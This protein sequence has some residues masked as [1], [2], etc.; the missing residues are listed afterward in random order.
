MDRLT[1]IRAEL[2]ALRPEDFD[3]MNEDANGA[4][5]LYALCDELVQMEDPGNWMSLLFALMERLDNVD[6]GSP[7]PIVHALERSGNQYQPLLA[8]SVR[9]KPTPLTV[10][11]VN[12]IINVSPADRDDWMEIL[13][14]IEHLPAA[15]QETV[16]EAR[17][18]VAYQRSRQTR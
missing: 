6:L 13:E 15:S 18:F 16:R 10:W 7:G 17:K 8:E 12:R 4:E 1:A 14:G 11:M 2:E 3:D 5:R 9:R